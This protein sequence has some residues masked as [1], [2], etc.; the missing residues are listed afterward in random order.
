MEEISLKGIYDNIAK[1]NL[2]VEIKVD[3]K[4]AYMCLRLLEAYLDENENETLCIFCDECGNWDL[5]IIN[6]NAVKHK[7]GE[8]E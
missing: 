6:R 7:A 5:S 8:Q 3:D 1:L 4:T 2:S